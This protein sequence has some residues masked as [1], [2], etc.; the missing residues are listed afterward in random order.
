MNYCQHIK[1]RTYGLE[2]NKKVAITLRQY[3]P[4][5]NV[6]LI[7]YIVAMTTDRENGIIRIVENEKFRDV[8]FEFNDDFDCLCY[9]DYNG[10][11]LVHH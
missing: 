1:D 5:V 6:E 8:I 2:P 10:D 9:V 3:E 4:G 11:Y 7:G